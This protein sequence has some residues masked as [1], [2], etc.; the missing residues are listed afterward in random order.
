MPLNFRRFYRVWQRN[1]DVF[2]RLWPAELGGFLLEPV[3]VLLALG[4][5]LGA[6]VGEIQ[7]LSY[8]QWVAPGIIASYAMFHS[9]FETTYGAYMRMETHRV[10]HGIIVTPVGVEGLV[11]GEI[12]WGAT[13]SL[14]SAIPLL[15]LAAILGLVTSPWAFLIVPAAF[16]LGLQFSSFFLMYISVVPSLALIN[17]F[18]T[19]VVI[20]MFYVSGVF[21]PTTQLP[22]VVEDLSWLLPLTPATHLIRALATGTISLEHLWALVLIL[23]WTA[24]CLPAAILLLRRR[25][26]Q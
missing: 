24:L 15:T 3:V 25:L 11:V 17:T 6:F 1:K 20:P 9:A 5:G 18:F 8:A 10:Y 2:L 4:Y 13:R 12:L 16:L 22:D 23:T 19:V 26:L 7:G 14:M 21:F